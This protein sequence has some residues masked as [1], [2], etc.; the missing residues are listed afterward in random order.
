MLTKAHEEEK[1]LAMILLNT[2]YGWGH[3]FVKITNP[4]KLLV[5]YFKRFKINFLLRL[6]ILYDEIL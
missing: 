3:F 2:L 1:T 5:R 4:L 6:K